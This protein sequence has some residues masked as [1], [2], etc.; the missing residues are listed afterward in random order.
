MPEDDEQTPPEKIQIT[1][2]L[3]GRSQRPFD[4]WKREWMLTPGAL[5]ILFA[6]STHKR[7]E[8]FILKASVSIVL[9]LTC[10]V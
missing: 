10:N 2:N 5:E 9:V 6:L 8:K 3:Q 7:L 1:A 4:C